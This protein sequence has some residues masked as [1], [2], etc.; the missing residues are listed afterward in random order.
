MAAEV[1]RVGA[2]ACRH[3]PRYGPARVREPRLHGQGF[4]DSRTRANRA[5]SVPYAESVG[6][7]A[8]AQNA[9]FEL[10]VRSRKSFCCLG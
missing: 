3:P 9:A 7:G 2:G 5:G 4:E 6:A 8:I 10:Y 1:E